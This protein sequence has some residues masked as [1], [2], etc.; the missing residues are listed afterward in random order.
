VSAR[1]EPVLVPQVLS[2]LVHGPGLYLDPT[3]GDAGH[4]CAL[5]DAEP[6]ARLLG[7]D[8]D[9]AALAFAGERLKPYGG[10]AALAHATF[11]EV[12]GVWQTHGRELLTGVLLD[13]GLSSRQIDDPSRGM[14]FMTDGPLDLRMDPSR[15]RSAA[16]RLAAVGVD[17]LAGLL[18]ELG[19][20]TGSG[21]FAR[22]IVADVRAGRLGSTGALRATLDRVAGGRAH[23][24]RVAQVFQALRMWVNEE[25]AD[26]AAMLDWLPGAV[27]PGGVV[28]T[29]A[30]HSGEDRRIKQALRGTRDER[31]SRRLPD[32][33][34]SR[35]PGSPW[36][37]LHRRVITADP[38]EVARNPRARSVRLRAFRRRT[39]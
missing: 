13:L 8:R 1:H 15:G 37:A 12:P 20:L 7:C 31:P 27:R 35:A 30:Y 4:A 29:L 34:G 36:E 14:S 18:R 28:V 16:E 26:L 3:L 32:I 9:P 33:P 2:F 5:L 23:P 25:R 11:Q 17:E 24:R 38:A 39:A 6:G 21:R 19:D 10:R 22:A